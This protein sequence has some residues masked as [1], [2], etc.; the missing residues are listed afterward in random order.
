MKTLRFLLM[1]TAVLST[2]MSFQSCLDDDDDNYWELQYPNALVT[3]KPVDANSCY[4]QLDDATTLL[5][6][7]LT[8]S[9]FGE[10]EVRALMNFKEVDASSG[11]YTKAVHVNW[12]DSILT[13][14]MV[15]DLALANDSVYGND[16]VEMIN[17]WVTIAEDGYLTLRFRTLWGNDN[18]PH[19]VNLL[20]NPDPEKPYE[21]EF[22]HNAFGDHYGVQADGLVAFNLDSL[23]DT[24]GK[25]VKL[26][27]KW[28]S[29]AGEKTAEFDYCTR[30]A[31]PANSAI[32][33]ERSV[34][35]VK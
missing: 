35:K 17:D 16:P 4:L 18:K 8:S 3:V 21:V 5:P 23:P 25:T 28:H 7:N 22:R 19:L 24:E 2:A 6:V 29:F 32:T 33:T 15:P 10:K 9:P 34:V 13:K 20:I 12:I 30:K 31:T 27:L 26:K 1:I 11:G 14:P